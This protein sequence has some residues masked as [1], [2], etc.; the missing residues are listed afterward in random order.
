M[1][2]I[3]LFPKLRRK[4]SSKDGE[5]QASK[6]K[7]A[8][9]SQRNLVF[10][11][12]AQLTYMSSISTSGVSRSELFAHASNL[13]YSSSEYFRRVHLLAQKL[14][15]DYAEGCRLVAEK[16]DIPEVKSFLLRFAGSLSSGED[17][18][19][20][21]LREAESLG[22]S[23]GN[24]YERDTESLKKWTDAYVTLVV[25][26]GLIVIVA[27]ISMMIYEVGVAI[28]VGMAMTMVFATCL[29]AWIIYASAPR[30]VKTRAKGASSDLQLLG[31][32]LLK[33]LAPIGLTVCALMLFMKIDLGWILIVGAI[34]VAIP[35]WVI[36]KDDKNVSKK[37]A[38]IPTVV[39]VLGGVT[40]AIGTTVT[41]AIGQIDRRS[42][43][44]LT[45]EITRLRQR[46]NAG[47]NPN[48]CWK[49]FVDETG[50]ELIERTISMFW[51]ALAMGG[52]AGKVGTASSM[53]SSKIAF[54]RATRSMVASTFRYLVL[55][56]HGAMVGLLLFIPQIMTLFTEQIA[57][58]ADSLSSSSGTNL[59]NSDVPVGDMFTFGNVDLGLVNMLVTFVVLVLTGA[60]AFAPKAAEGGHNIKILNNLGI[61]MMMTGV[62]MI[63]VPIG[64]RGLFQ[65]IV[66]V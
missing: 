42:M 57:A 9:S 56:L 60:N 47:I 30:E 25:A 21:L 18:D 61:M 58:S 44:S 37:D 49:K 17:E 41:E 31:V 64:A 52:H 59:P 43:G 63:A 32:K 51:D 39:R 35:G 28:I 24:Q 7:R 27:V 11:L 6:P 45:P 46:L 2:S 12:F 19:E 38:D 36:S 8:T 53:Y 4:A 15:I 29:G 62:L 20:F 22:A 3:K 13:P 10:D 26:S 34:I 54:L 55:P 14:N 50:S 65:S 16:T 33:I 40:S 48:L 23:Y 5:G 66:E 1:N